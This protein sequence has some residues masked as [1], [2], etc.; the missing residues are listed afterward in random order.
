MPIHIRIAAATDR[1]QVRS[2]NQDFHTYCIPE[3]GVR[4]SKG[5]LLAVA[6]GMGG[7][8]GGEQASRLAVE[9]LMAEYYRPAQL[10]IR[11]SLEKAA[12]KANA[13]VK[14]RAAEEPTLRGMG[15]T[16]TALVLQQET[17][18]YAHVGDSRGYL[19]QNG[20][21][22][23]F[24]QDHSLVA[25]LVRAGVIT[26]QDARKHPDR[27]IITRAIGMEMAFDVDVAELPAPP[28]CGQTYLLCCDGLHGQLTAAEI[29]SILLGTGDLQI[30][31]Q[32]LV[33]KANAYGGPDNITVM[34]ARVENSGSSH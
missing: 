20:T 23:Q 16:L 31:C 19:I 13:A 34:L 12:I 18:C 5:I 6:D 4:D 28:R 3:L 8:A 26:P 30:A 27:N 32:Q 10:P 21:L 24:T 11:E 2:Q 22:T 33:D 9:T 15:S 1:G 17:I 25:D 7:H 29:Q 14:Q